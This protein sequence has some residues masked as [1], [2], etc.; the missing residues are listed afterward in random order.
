MY[1]ASETAV[2]KYLCCSKSSQAKTSKAPE[3]AQGKLIIII[4]FWGGGGGRGGRY[5]T[6]EG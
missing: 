3:T 1:K 5:P 4:F 2:I 6:P